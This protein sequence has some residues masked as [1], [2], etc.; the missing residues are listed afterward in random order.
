MADERLETVLARLE[1]ERA[2]ADR[3]YNDALTA[4]DR[5][6]GS[7]PA[8]AEAPPP[9]DDSRRADLNGAWN[10]LPDGPPAADGSLK[11]RL[12]GFVWRLVGPALEQQA[13]FNSILVDHLNRNAPGEAVARET[14]RAL[15]AAVGAELEARQRFQ[16]TLVQYLQ[17]ITLYVDTKDRAVDGQVKVVGAGLGAVADEGLKR[18]ESLSARTGRITAELADLRATASLAQ[19]TS[20]SLKREVERL[21]AAGAA[22]GSA[23]AGAPA[24]AAAAAPDLDAFKYLGFEDQFRGSRDAIT[25]G[26][27]FFGTSGGGG[28]AGGGAGAGIDLPPLYRFSNSL[29]AGVV[30]PA[31]V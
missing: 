3:A 12:R 28:G 24:A 19:Q 30:R 9:F 27:T 13:R 4:V 5:A 25:S 29:R 31:K 18:T 7:L 2:D 22:G 26:A 20:L 1:R 16:S 8:P 17:T 14:T 21:L 23:A 11:G 6:L 10:L 15:V